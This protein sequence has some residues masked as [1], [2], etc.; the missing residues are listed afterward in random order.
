MFDSLFTNI[1]LEETIEICINELFK[2]KSNS[3]GFKK[4]EFKYLLSSATKELYFT[5][6]NVLYK[7]I[8]RIAMG[9]PLGPSL[10]NAFLA[11][12]EQNWLD[13]CPLEYRKQRAL[14]ADLKAIQ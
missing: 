9:S 1:P 5:F 3:H 6:N 8:D 12:H 7:Q 14:D 11:Y 2:I 4:S 13:T 10:A